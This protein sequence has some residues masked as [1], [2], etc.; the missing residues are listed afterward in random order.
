MNPIGFEKGCLVNQ[1]AEKIQ[2]E[3]DRA[4]KTA[5]PSV[6]RVKFPSH[7]RELDYFNDQFDLKV[8]D[9]VFVDGKLSGQRGRI[10]A[11]SKHFKIKIEDYKHVIGLADTCVNGQFRNAGSHLVT[12][13]RRVLPYD[14]FRTWVLPPKDDDTEYFVHFDEESID[15]NNSNAWPMHRDIMERGIDYYRDNRVLYLSLDGSRGR[16][17]V[18]STHPYEVE[19]S[20]DSE[21]IQTLSCDCPCGYH[22]K[23]EVAALLQLR[24]T[25]EIINERYASDLSGSTYFAAVFTPLFCQ[26]L[27]RQ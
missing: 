7:N 10:V 15:L 27:L 12:F 6:V 17:I 3:A 25:L 14:Q 1:N 13:D 5:V 9:L 16:A 23:H 24:E 21:M 2:E 22:C 26:H 8:G 11:V 19:F 4:E 18:D 20:C